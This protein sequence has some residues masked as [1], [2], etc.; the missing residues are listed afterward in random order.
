MKN[1]LI[2]IT[3]TCCFSIL[4][5]AAGCNKQSI[6]APVSNVSLRFAAQVDGQPLVIG[7][8]RYP[9]A[10]GSG[11]FTVEDFKV[12]IS[13][14][15]LKNTATGDV[16]LEEDSYHLLRYANDSAEFEIILAGVE[17]GD[18]D[19]IE[20]AIGVDPVRNLSIESLR[21]LNPNNQM[22]W[23]WDVGYK[24]VL[25]EGMFYPENDAPPIPLVYHVGFSENYKELSFDLKN[26]SRLIDR[27]TSAIDFEVDIMEMFRNPKTID[28]NVLPSV[29]FDKKE[30]KTFADNYADMI[31]IGRTIEPN[32]D[33]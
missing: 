21:D 22:A 15:A 20:M 19:T 8:Q 3:S 1:F 30:A 11:A 33:H 25:L 10:T 17:V 31:R 12:Y 24:F 26:N 13:N 18:Y 23:N 5:L 27:S 32:E 7:G 28:F 29:K 9:S 6:D 4:I 16:Y 2:R 14:I